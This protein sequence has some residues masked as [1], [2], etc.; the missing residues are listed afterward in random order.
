MLK[1]RDPYPLGFAAAAA[2]LLLCTAVQAG[3]QELSPARTDTDAGVSVTEEQ[4]LRLAAMQRRG[5]LVLGS[6]ALLNIAGGAY[7]MSATEGKSYYFWQMNLLWNLVNLGIA[8]GGYAGALGPAE[9]ADSFAVLAEYHSFS[10]I[11]LL[12]AGLDAAYI[13]TGLFLRERAKSSDSHAERLEGYGNALVLQG[14]FL[15][16]FDAVL[17][18]LNEAAITRATAALGGGPATSGA[19]M[20]GD[21]VSI[22]PLPGG[23]SAGIRF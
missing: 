10:K 19:L 16:L 23:F 13:M 20:L 18:I 22:R 21:E 6:W 2:L 11:L 5:M 8:G 12:N 1:K 14:G 3:S 4:S 7:G 15:L 17:V 9:T